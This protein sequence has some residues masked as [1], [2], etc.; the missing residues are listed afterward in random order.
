MMR[1][2]E[3]PATPWLH[4]LYTHTPHF[5]RKLGGLMWCANWAVEAAHRQVKDDWQH[6]PKR[7]GHE[8]GSGSARLM[9]QRHTLRLHLRRV[10]KPKRQRVKQHSQDFYE[11]VLQQFRVRFGVAGGAPA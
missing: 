2:L 11:K 6:T 8:G 4:I 3:M 5:A 9:L 10:Y 1:T 7:G